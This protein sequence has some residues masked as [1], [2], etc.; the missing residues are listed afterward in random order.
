MQLILSKRFG[1]M[2]KIRQDIN[3]G[4]NLRRLRK[5][6]KLTQEKVAIEMQL[7]GCKITRKEGKR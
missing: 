7:A 4:S 3:I 1:N 5:S 6:K 2:N